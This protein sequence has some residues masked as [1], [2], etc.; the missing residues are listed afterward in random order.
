LHSCER[1]AGN[2]RFARRRL[3]SNDAS[4][5]RR[6]STPTSQSPLGR[7]PHRQRR[8]QRSPCYAT[9][10][11]DCKFGSS[12]RLP[13]PSHRRLD[14][15]PKPSSVRA[16]RLERQLLAEPASAAAGGDQLTG[17][18]AATIALTPS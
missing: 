9:L 5:E 17:V 8:R 3:R 11:P 7:E 14:C 18:S 15:P 10:R 16:I 6:A 2:R 4:R 1:E 13:A 12:P